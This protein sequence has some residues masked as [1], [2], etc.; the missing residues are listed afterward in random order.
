MAAAFFFASSSMAAFLLASSSSCFCFQAGTAPP[1]ETNPGAGVFS[2]VGA[3]AGSL[4]GESG[5]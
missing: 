1:E 3:A 2:G 4:R 5:P